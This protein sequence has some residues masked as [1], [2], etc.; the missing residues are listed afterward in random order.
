VKTLIL[1]VKLSTGACPSDFIKNND[2]GSCYKIFTS[3]Q[4]ADA[5]PVSD[6]R[7]NCRSLHTLANL[8]S[9][10]TIQE[11]NYLSQLLKSE[12][13]KYSADCWKYESI[14]LIKE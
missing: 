4:L 13:G 6:A 10:E 5:R 8:V 12:P 14:S 7:D 1:Y 9:V 2:I 11:K 3:I